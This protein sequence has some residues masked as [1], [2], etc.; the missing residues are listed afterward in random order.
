MTVSPFGQCVLS[1]FGV[2]AQKLKSLFDLGSLRCAEWKSGLLFFEVTSGQAK[3]KSSSPSKDPGGA[4]SASMVHARRYRWSL[5][6]RTLEAGGNRGDNVEFA[7]RLMQLMRFA[8]RPA[9]E[10]GDNTFPH[11]SDQANAASHGGRGCS[12]GP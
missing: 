4:D 10:L 1:P 3:E 7:H 5:R 2:I 8:P 12:I 9:K 6:G 11:H